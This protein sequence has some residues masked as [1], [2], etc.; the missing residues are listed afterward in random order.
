MPRLSEEDPLLTSIGAIILPSFSNFPALHH[1]VAFLRVSLDAATGPTHELL[2]RGARWPVMEE[3][4]AF[5]SELR[6]QGLI[7]RLDLTFVVQRD[8]FREMGDAV[9]LA[10][11]FGADSMGF[12]RLTNW[13]TFTSKQYADRAVFMAAHPEH[14]AFLDAM[15]DPRLRDPIASL[16]ELESFVALN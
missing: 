7:D 13:G 11:R 16:G 4:L 12:F 15:R 8:N 1:R 9:D 5:A 2:R 14:G 10:R 6:A 3:N